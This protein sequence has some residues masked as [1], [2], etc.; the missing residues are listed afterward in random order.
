MKK[1]KP[2]YLLLCLLL[3]L[4]TALACTTVELCP[5]ADHPHLATIRAEFDWSGNDA[6]KPERMNIVASR[7]L[8]TWRTHGI[9][10]TKTGHVAP[11]LSAIHEK[12]S[13]ETEEETP[14]T[15][16]QE[17][18]QTREEEGAGGNDGTND[19]EGEETPDAPAENPETTEKESFK[20][21]GGEYNLFAINTYR[22]LSIDSLQCY[23][24]HPEAMVDTLYL[25]MEE[26][27][28][29]DLPEL[30]GIDMPDFNPKYKYIQNAGRIF[31][32]ATRG[33]TIRTGQTET[34]RFTPVPVSQSVTI[35]FRVRTVGEVQVDSL[36]AEI[37]GVCGRMNIADA[38]LDTANLYRIIFRPEVEKKVEDVITY[39]AVL[40]VLGIIPSPKESYLIGPG[41]IQ[42]AVY[43]SS[44]KR[45]RIYYAGANPRQ[46]IIDAK[47]TEKRE[48]GRTYLARTE[49][50]TIELDGELKID[51]DQILNQKED[52][53]DIWF[54]SDTKIDVDV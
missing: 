11:G 23:L 47:M 35:K 45:R 32:A 13:Q 22:G 48:D 49:P 33:V 17:K 3:L 19:P 6:D 29:N 4:C 5:E 36:I 50:V 42:V 2:I 10:D 30:K 12:P 52:N 34:L 53:F 27:S 38:Y 15:E 20:L 54:D 28:R 18:P 37:S 8:N 1:R 43:A 16:G 21:K 31:Y 24:D 26:T 7:I 46:N 44:G 39:K 51:A 41:I 14:A 25:H 9:A 40:H